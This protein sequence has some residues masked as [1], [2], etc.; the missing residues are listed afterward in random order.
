[1]QFPKLIKQT[2]LFILVLFFNNNVIAQDEECGFIH[3]S[4]AQRYY[5]SIKE[6]IKMK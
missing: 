4:E 6:E 2:A 1:M 5:D 3:T